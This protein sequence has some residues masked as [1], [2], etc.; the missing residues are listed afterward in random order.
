[1]AG[2]GFELRRLARRDDLSGVVQGYAYAALTTSGPWLFTIAALSA[3][4]ALGTPST[5]PQ[6]LATFR[7]VIVYNFA[8]SLVLS[9]SITTIATRRLADYIYQKDVRQAPAL[10]GGALLAVYAVSLPPVAWFYFSY[11]DLEPGI[12]LL[13][14]MNYMLVSGIWVVSVFLTALKSYQAVTVAFLS[15]MALSVIAAGVL[16]YEFAVA[17]MLGGFNLGLALILVLLASRVLAEYPTRSE[18]PFE[19]VPYFRRYWDLALSALVFNLAQ[20]SD[21]WIMWLAPEHEAPVKGLF[22]NPDYDGA[23][24]LACLSVIPAMAAFTMIIET[25]FYEQ[26]LRF[27]DDIQKHANLD[28]IEAN[29]KALIQAFAEGCR[30][31]LILQGSISLT[32][33]LISP[34]LFTVTGAGFRQLA[35]F[36]FGLAGSFFQSGFLFLCVVLSYFDQRRLQLKMSTVFLVTN[37]VFSYAAMRSGVMFYGY[38]YFLASLVTFGVAFVCVGRLISSLPYQTFVVT[39]TS[40]YPLEAG[41]KS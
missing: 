14:V 41:A 17:G 16:A 40:I 32:A 25:R 18:R 29:H 33:I 1:M 28:R 10:M 9:A 7:G 8:F 36:R 3:V 2:I 20:W 39:N 12:R 11:A 4:V 5:T 22:S 19:F 31:F 24:F 23:M 38:G 13:A 15:G 21:K 34:Q 27:Y 37:I 30:S 35:I 6:E 26:Y